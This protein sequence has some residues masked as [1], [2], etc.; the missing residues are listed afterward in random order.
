VSITIPPEL[1]WLSDVLAGQ[2]WPASNE[3]GLRA[4]GDAWYEAASGFNGLLDPVEKVSGQVS[5]SIS[6]NIAGQFTEFMAGLTQSLPQFADTANSIGDM[7]YEA[8]LNVQYAKLMILVMMFWAAEQIIELAQTIWGLALIPAIEAVARITISAI[9]KQLLKSVLTCV[10]S[11][12]GADAAIQGLQFA[13]GERH[14]WNTQSTLEWLEM[15]GLAGVV[16]GLFHI[17]GDMLAPD[18][19]K[20][21]LGH[22]TL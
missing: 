15:G 8:F 1:A 4:I 5:E 20:S 17:G 14:E 3:D 2:N 22:E 21:L 7:M 19:A 11:T 9:A 10:V 16:G 12:V 6:G 13:L 18:F